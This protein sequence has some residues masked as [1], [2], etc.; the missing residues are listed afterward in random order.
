MP[1][2][3]TS[4]RKN[5]RT[6][7]PGIEEIFQQYP[8]AQWTA[9]GG[10]P[11]AFPVV[12]IQ[13]SG[14]NRIVV[15]ER[16]FRDG[17]KLDDTGTSPTEWSMTVL[18]ENTL[19]ESSNAEPDLSAINGVPLYP[20]VLNAL[21]ESF[22]THET[23]DLV[24]PTRGAV[25]ARCQSYSRSEN[26][27]ERDC[28]T[29]EVTFLEDNE[30][31]VDAQSFTAPSAAGSAGYIAAQT[32]FDE[33]S[34][35]MFDLDI[36]DLN[37]AMAQLDG[38]VNAPGEYMQDLENGA[39]TVMN[40]VDRAIELF[41]QPGIDGRDILLGPGGNKIERDL[42]KQKELAGQ[43]KQS[44]V[45]GQQALITKK[46]EQAYSV[47]EIASLENKDAEEL[48]GNNPQL[49]NLLVI[50]KNTPVRMYADASPTG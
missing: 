13:E 5:F 17:A 8:V 36:Q 15:R 22:R 7:D 31:N 10:E 19:S 45:K 42:Q 49:P 24:V 11:I 23:G 44:A 43:A 20:D 6:V 48:I 25:R 47:Y 40:N 4:L 34:E 35:G 46:Y 16:P 28:A 18:F 27:T 38:F 12:R 14:G 29:L 30:D 26:A 39:N 32:E 9:D 41:S 1:I 50:P 21:I 33:Q 2:E 37:M 3:D